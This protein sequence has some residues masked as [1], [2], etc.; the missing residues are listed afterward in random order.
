MHYVFVCMRYVCVCVY[1]FVVVF[2]FSRLRV[3]FSVHQDMLQHPL[4][5]QGLAPKG[6]IAKRFCMTEILSF[7]FFGNSV[8]SKPAAAGQLVYNWSTIG[9]DPGGWALCQDKKHI[10]VSAYVLKNEVRM[11]WK[12][13]AY[14][15]KPRPE[16]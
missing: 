2:V 5:S 11:G 10:S 9:R 7:V 3:P 15:F 8:F 1:V 4:P 6:V 14:F 12:K 13:L 16:P